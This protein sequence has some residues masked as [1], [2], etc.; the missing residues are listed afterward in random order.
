VSLMQSTADSR[1][2]P[3]RLGAY[4]P[5]PVYYRSGLYRRLAADPRIDFAA[6]FSSSAGLRPGDL[7]YGRPVSFDTDALAGFD[8]TFLR[9][10]GR[11]EADGSFVS[12]LDFDIVPELLRRR[13][14]VLWLHG[15]Y[16]ATHLIAA[17]TQLVR[18]GR[19]FVREEQT[20]L[21]PR[22]VWKQ[23]LKK[24]LLK[25]L[26]SRSTGLYIG[27][28]NREWFRHHGMPNKRLFHVPF[29]VDNDAFRAEARRLSPDGSKLRAAFG[30]SPDAGPVVLS[31]AR[32]DRKKQPLLLLDAF[33][34]LRANHRCALL[35]VGSGPCEDEMRNF[36]H[37]H[38]IPDVA[39]AGFL[40]QSEISRAYAVAELV[41]LASVS[42]TWGLVISEAMNFAL[43][44]VV[45][46][47][48]GCVADLVFHGENGYVFPHDRPDELARYLGM[49]VADPARRE[50]F[51]RRAI[52]IIAPWNDDA[53]AVGLLAAVRTAVGERRWSE[54]E[55]RPR[56]AERILGALPPQVDA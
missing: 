13:F 1:P 8:S 34:R 23:A 38:G 27:T 17:T 29:C 35:L 25:V 42:E 14:D 48:V 55:K 18:G 46:D 50:S 16:S 5:S 43:P 12:L 3:I 41:A 11:T 54:A 4:A 2:R 9:R 53:A 6:I 40:N 36:V 39:F 47:K 51:G 37:V 22:P 19:L 44:V 30:I 26:F 52:E 20:L 24:A 28:R 31:V 32:L 15:Y 7:G 45:S 33:R 21:N 10:A 49:L 56:T